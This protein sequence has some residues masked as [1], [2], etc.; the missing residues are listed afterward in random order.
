MV[1][2]D[3]AVRVSW[4]GC[5]ADGAGGTVGSVSAVIGILLVASVRDAC[6][7]ARAGWHARSVAARGVARR[8]RSAATS[9]ILDKILRMRAWIAVSGRADAIQLRARYAFCMTT[10]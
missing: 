9:L 5:A 6:G 7:G 3:M 2:L 10:G 8:G 4:P 1:A